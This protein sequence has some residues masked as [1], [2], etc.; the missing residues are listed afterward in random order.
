MV[1]TRQVYLRVTLFVMLVTNCAW[2]ASISGNV[3]NG[4]GKS[5]R[6]YLTVHNP[7]GGSTGLGTSIAS[8]GSFSISGVP[9]GPHYVWAFVD[10]Q[11]TAIQHANDPRGQ[12]ATITVPTTGNVAAASFAVPT[13]LRSLRRSLRR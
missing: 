11:G 5:G 8:A 13:Q 2:A 10:T 7:D 3:T 6:I 1:K 12:S 9:S 4:T